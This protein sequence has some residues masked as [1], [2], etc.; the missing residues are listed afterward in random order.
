MAAGAELDARDAVSSL[1][2][3]H[4]TNSL[5]VG[6]VPPHC[7]TSTSL[8]LGLWAQIGT[9]ALITAGYYGYTAVA[10]ALLAAGADTEVTG[11]VGWCTH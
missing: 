5:R 11:T 10:K 7:P 6:R 2:R 3:S 4:I 1:G 9:T 8:L